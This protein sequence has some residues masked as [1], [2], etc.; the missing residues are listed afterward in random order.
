MPFILGRER[1][2]EKPL[3]H[4]HNTCITKLWN[5]IS[6]CA[7]PLVPVLDLDRGKTTTISNLRRLYAGFLIQFQGIV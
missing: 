6:A 3:Q 5:Y 2:V 7:R 4:T 1:G